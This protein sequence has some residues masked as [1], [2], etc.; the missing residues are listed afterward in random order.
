MRIGWPRRRRAEF[1]H[2]QALQRLKTVGFAP[3]TIYDIGAYHG[4]WSRLA[5]EIFPAD[6]VLFEAN[7]DNEPALKSSGF[8][9]VIVALGGTDGEERTLFLPRHA[10]A[11]GASFYRE[12][13]E[14]Y[15]GH[16][17]RVEHVRTARLDTIAAAHGLNPPDLIKLD[18]QGAELDV[19]A[20]ADHAMAHCG[21][22]IA[23]MSLLPHNEGG[24]LIAGIMAGIERHG[25]RC[26]DICEVHRTATG[27]LLQLDGL[28]VSAPWFGKFRAAAGPW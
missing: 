17:L 12:N 8:R 4:T 18:V 19:L 2:R 20:G 26:V 3:R 10:V 22:L 28:F 25:L 7:A 16:N 23:E 27:A 9:Y 11:T 24:P 21:A 14:H 15:A 1:S 5:A 6:F 13:T